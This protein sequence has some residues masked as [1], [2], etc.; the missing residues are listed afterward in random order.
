MKLVFFETPLFSRY[1]PDYLSEESYRELQNTLLHNPEFGDI[2]QG[3]GGFRKMRWQDSRRQKG[4]RGGL[5]IIYYYF[6]EQHQ[7]W[8]F[9]IY[10]KDEITD[11]TPTEKKLL[12]QA[13]E[14]ELANRKRGYNHGKT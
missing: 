10:D 14:I 13:I 2:V 3:T 1:R 8:F 5:R 9:T 4:K 11:L 6:A 12:K 7:I